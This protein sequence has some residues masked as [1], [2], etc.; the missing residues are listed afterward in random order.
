MTF[1]NGDPLTADDA[2]FSLERNLDPDSGTFWADWFVNVKDIVATDDLTVEVTLKQPDEAFNTVHGDRG[3][4]GGPAES[5][6]RSRAPT[7][8]V[9]RAA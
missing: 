8:A 1:S 5:S 9:R 7:T 2:V 3:G 4:H 6:S